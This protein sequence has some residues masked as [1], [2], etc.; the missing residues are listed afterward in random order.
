MPDSELSYHED[1]DQDALSLGD[2]LE[3]PNGEFVD[4]KARETGVRLSPIQ[5]AEV[6]SSLCSSWHPDLTLMQLG[7]SQA[8]SRSSTPCITPASTLNGLN[9]HVLGMATFDCVHHS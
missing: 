1:T 8:A 2:S 5:T 9:S 3:D 6:G 4:E 7:L